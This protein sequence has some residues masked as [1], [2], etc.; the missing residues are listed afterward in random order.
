MERLLNVSMKKSDMKQTVFSI[1]N[2]VPCAV[3]NGTIKSVR[4]TGIIVEFGEGF[5]GFV[6]AMH[7]LDKPV[8]KWQ[9]R[10][11]KGY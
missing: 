4:D 5:T 1:E 11:K 10:F 2:V 9:S 8:D 3:L 6:C 7:V